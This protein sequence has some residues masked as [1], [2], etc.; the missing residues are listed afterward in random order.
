MDHL[1]QI[2]RIGDT[3]LGFGQWLSRAIDLQVLLEETAL[4]EGGL[5]V[6]AHHHQVRRRLESL[7]PRQES[8][9]LAGHRRDE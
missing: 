9:P 1:N 4:E 5:E 2:Q 6:A 8:V 3:D 7:M